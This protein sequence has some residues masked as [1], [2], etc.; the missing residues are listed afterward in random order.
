MAELA[1]K[2]QISAVTIY[3]W[4]QAKLPKAERKLLYENRCLKKENE[5]LYNLI[6]KLA[7][8]LKK[9]GPGDQSKKRFLS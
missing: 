5:D 4:M 8:E 6:G 3:G 2:H 9:R 1:K 7:A